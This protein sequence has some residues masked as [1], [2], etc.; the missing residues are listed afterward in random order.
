MKKIENNNI[1]EDMYLTSTGVIQFIF[2]AWREQQ[3]PKAELAL[4]KYCEYLAMRRYGKAATE[5]FQEL[6]KK[7]I[8][9]GV[10][11]IKMTFNKYIT[12][13]TDV[14]NYITS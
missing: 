7:D 13:Q 8:S 4:Q 2:S 11:W 9:E 1:L 3:L 14:I 5:I 12:N 6:E 10:S